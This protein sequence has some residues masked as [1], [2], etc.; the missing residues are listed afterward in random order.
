VSPRARRLALLGTLVLLG[1]LAAG[2][3]GTYPLDG[4]EPT[5]IRRLQGYR[6]AQEAAK[7]PKLSPGALLPTAATRLHLAEAAP[8]W[9]LAGVPK[10]PSLQAALESIFAQRDPSYAVAVVDITD[11]SAPIWAGL[12]EDGTQA[13]GS[14]GKV[15]CLVALF[16]GLRRAFPEM[17]DRERLLRDHVVEATDW[18][19]VDEHAVPHYDDASGQN[20]FWIIKPGE[21]FTLAEWVDHMVSASANAAGATVWKEAMLL[22]RFGS[23]YPPS[24]EDEEAFFRQTPKPELT[25]LSQAVIDEPLA[26]V[27][28]DLG[29]LRQGS[30]WTKTGKAKIPGIA[31][32]ASPRELV[33]LLL[34]LEQGRLVDGWSSLEMKRYLYTTRRRYRYAFPPELGKAAVYFKSGSLYQ[35]KPEEGYRCGKYKGNAKNYMNSIAIVESPAQAGPDQRRYLVALLSNVLKVNSA[36]DHARLGAAI[37]AAVRTRR[38]TAVKEVGT[39]AEVREAGRGD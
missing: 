21:R 7:G 5:G 30:M 38:P 14:V 24:R 19:L 20:R 12:R 37:D 8:A 23:A 27:G 25:K 18:V 4:A 28:L 32:Y 39:E 13:P 16:D 33:R 31:S 10:D 17:A 22:R 15:L 34:R 35:C 29:K 11:P 2:P 3:A 26:A 1:A 9:D 6:N 36:W